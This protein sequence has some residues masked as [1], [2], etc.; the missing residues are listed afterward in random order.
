MPKVK[1]ALISVFDKTGIVDFARLLSDLGVEII[2][3]GGTARHLNENGIKTCTISDITAFPEILNGRVKTLHPKIIGGIL[4]LRD[5]D[6]QIKETELHG[7]GLID[8]VVVNL[9]PF[10]EIIRNKD[11]S[12][13]D[14]LEN[15]D[16]GGCT[17]IRAAAKNFINVAVVTLPGQY[18][19]VL[20]EI[21]STKGEISLETR[22]ILACEA[23]AQSS[24]Y[25]SKIN[26]YLSTET[27]SGTTFPDRFQF[28]FEKVQ[29]LRYGENP[30]QHAAW[31]REIGNEIFGLNAAKQLHGK[32]LSFNNILDLDTALGIV[33]EFQM[34]CAVIIK[35][36]NPCGLCIAQNISEAYLNAK[37]T[38]PVS[39]FGGIVGVNRIVDADAARAISEIF[40]EAIIAPGFE[41]DA[42]KTL[43][44]KKNL[45]ILE[46]PDITKSTKQEL[47]IKKV[48]GGILLQDQDFFKLNDINLSVVTT[49]QPNAEEW[50]AM[51]LGW[52]VAKWVKSNAIV[53][54]SKD[55]TI[56]IGAGQMSRVDSTQIAIE[57]A[58]R[59]GLLLEGT[60]VASDAFYPFRDGVDVAAK[61]GAR[62]I[63]Q[64]G[65]SI[66][67]EEVIKAADE[68]DIT[69]VFTNIR[70]F[71]H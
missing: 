57:K 60:A 11:C 50:D 65:G 69:M 9:Y 29:D 63:I 32:E 28:Q 62:A 12:L 27:A 39:A 8:L 25:D 68:H 71:R 66:R 43:Q 46:C 44:S 30:H 42:L 52:Q 35:H 15:I 54:T 4:A 34:P 53:F 56:G 51:K 3:T 47:D 17:L 24:S 22:R 19:K 37:A 40:T 49:R 7:I 5:S 26:T 48:Q 23:F 2:S 55:R 20:N 18:E 61:A 16:I 64:P 41:S 21:K 36:T 13:S 38:D 70:H 58:K 14:A 45:R 67:D 33:Q 6:S 59:L 10:E 31:Y 1:R